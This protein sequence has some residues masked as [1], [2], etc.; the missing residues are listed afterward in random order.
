MAIKKGVNH[1]NNK[2]RCSAGNF[3]D[4]YERIE[5]QDKQTLAV[6]MFIELLARLCNVLRLGS[7]VCN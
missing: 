5:N 6:W 2:G 3:D 7:E 4:L 1:S